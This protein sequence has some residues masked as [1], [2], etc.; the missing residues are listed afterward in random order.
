[1]KTPAPRPDWLAPEGKEQDYGEHG[2]PFKLLTER[3]LK[4]FHDAALMIKVTEDGIA[5][6]SSKHAK[7]RRE[8]ARISERRADLV[9][10]LLE[11]GLR[12]YKWPDGLSVRVV[13]VEKTSG[14]ETSTGASSF[15]LEIN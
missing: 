15:H 8:V 13:D 11:H 6:A 2:V 7:I 5:R 4:E 9:L 12:E 10:A 14:R 3:T 1:M